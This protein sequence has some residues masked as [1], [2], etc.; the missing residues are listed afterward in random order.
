MLTEAMMTGVGA[1]TAQGVVGGP[2][3]IDE[4]LMTGVPA[5]PP[6]E[7]SIGGFLRDPESWKGMGNRLLKGALGA[8]DMLLGAPA[9]AAGWVKGVGEALVAAAGGA[10]RQEIFTKLMD[11][12]LPT[13]PIPGTKLKMSLEQLKS[14]LQSTHSILTG[15]EPA[16]LSAIS[17]VIDATAAQV[18]KTAG[19]P[20]EITQKFIGGLMDFGGVKGLHEG[21]KAGVKAAVEPRAQTPE[22]VAAARA[23]YAPAE[24]AVAEAVKSDPFYQQMPE[25]PLRKELDAATKAKRADVRA[26]FAKDPEAADHLAWTASQAAEAHASELVAEAMRTGRTIDAADFPTISERVAEITAKPAAEVTP[27][28]TATLADYNQRM[29][30]EHSRRV[31]EVPKILGGEGKVAPAEGTEPPALMQ[32]AEIPKGQEA[33]A[34]RPLTG[35]EAPSVDAQVAE[36]YGEQRGTLLGGTK[37]K[38]SAATPVVSALLKRQ[39][40]FID[41]DMAPYVYAALGVGSAAAVYA[42]AKYLKGEEGDLI[43]GL[44]MA[45]LLGITAASRGKLAEVLKAAP[46][47]LKDRTLVDLARTG[48]SAALEKI[49]KDNAAPLERSLRTFKL[50]PGVEAADVV[51]RVM[52]KF[53]TDTIKRPADAVGGFRGD[54]KVSSFLF[55]AVKNEAIKAMERGRLDTAPIHEALGADGRPLEETIGDW[56]TSPETVALNHALVTKMQAALDRLPEHQRAL[57]DKILL[58]GKSYDEAAAEL[59]MP[60]GS[61]RSGLSR[62]KDALQQSLREYKDLQAGKADPA[63]L[64]RLAL[65]TGGAIAGAALNDDSV[66]KGALEGAGI[67]FGVAAATM[68][69]PKAAIEAIKAGIAPDTRIRIDQFANAHDAGMATAERSIWQQAREVIKGALVKADRSEITKA[70]QAGKVSSLPPELQRSAKVA[71]D[72]FKSAAEAAQKVGVLGDLIDDYVTNLW[73]LSGK[74]ADAWA[75]I[76]DRAGGPSM[77]GESRFAIK[78]KIANLEMGKAL[79]LVPVTE[80]VA[81]IMQI[82][83]KSLARSMENAKMLK[84]LRSELDPLTGKNLIM[85][86]EKAPHEYKVIDSPQMR[87]MRVH[88]DIEPSMKF[89]FE[90]GAGPAALQAIE[91]VNMMIKRSA[92]SASLFHAKALLDGFVGANTINKTLLA[93]GAAAGAAYGMASGDNPISTAMIGAGAALMLPGMKHVGQAMVPGI[94][95]VNPYLKML[96]E[97]KAGDVVGRLL[98]SGLKISFEK[99]KLADEDVGGSFYAGFT[100]AQEFLDKIVP[101]AGMPV[102]AFL[103]LNHAVDTFM[104][105]RLHAGFKLAIAAQKLEV[106][107]ESNARAHL[108]DPSVK[109]KTQ[110]ELAAEAS[111]FTNDVFGGLN[112]RRMAEETTTKW[113]RDLVLQAY[114]PAGRRVAQL[115]IFAPDWT[116][117]T[118]RAATRA[119][120]P[121]VADLNPAK[122]IDSFLNPQNATHL[123]RQYIMRSALYYATIANGINYAL[124]GQFLWDNLD[125]TF[126]NTGDGRKIQWSKHAFEPV[127]WV[128]HPGQQALNKLGF[129]PK[130]ALNQMLGTEWLSTAGK[131]KPMD[132]SLT[133]RLAHAAKSLEPIAMQQALSPAADLGSIGSGF[134]GVPIYGKKTP[135][136][137]EEKAALK[138]LHQ[139]ADYKAAALQRRIEKRGALK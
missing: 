21:I 96:L 42:V 137:L 63:L 103:A 84:S 120:A 37:P 75:R 102:K 125:W 51:Q 97:G 139:S 76:M 39:G 16:D 17:R 57:I 66:L 107:T 38:A 110:D 68:V 36:R 49:Y 18:E 106:L 52:E 74:N 28:E 14:P 128:E 27:E 13:I 133:G 89:L 60:V 138:E 71:Q 78:R 79:G 9:S 108:K 124:S 10:P 92:V 129:L 113:G 48:D 53:L 99:G 4:S 131:M 90:P 59:D 130:E 32:G 35:Y 50:P 109:L 105:E 31:A 65:I 123:H 119:F 101:G 23:S 15:E 73:D 85:T 112:W 100:K 88:P 22:S 5:A 64:G 94:F 127:H 47:A 43:P 19:I 136:V 61:V 34:E 7:P 80:D 91:A 62:A 72:F 41:K 69:H 135:Q 114:S 11:E 87:G 40:G 134:V 122:L 115:A 126:L 26:A 82:Y 30:A 132:T 33:P 29:A 58:E 116:M 56:K 1:P 6:P 117:S 86:A 45:G 83:G 111:S 121:S 93:G 55:G 2:G 95:G 24:E 8:G 12:Q 104:W 54:A 44:G 25:P 46:D 81:S 20:K 98:N 3:V 118:T 70:I 77:S 67:G